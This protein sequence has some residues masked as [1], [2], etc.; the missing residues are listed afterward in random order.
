[1][2]RLRR[3]MRVWDWLP[4]FRAVAEEEHLTRAAGRLHLTPPA[5]SRTLKLL[6]EDLERPL[7]HREGRN[8]VLNPAGRR[9]LVAVRAAMRLVHDAVDDVEQ[10]PVVP[11]TIASTG[12]FTTVGLADTL[13]RVVGA[14]PRV[15]P[16]VRTVAPPEIDKALLQGDLDLM[17]TQTPLFRPGLTTVALCET[18][19]SV[20]CG[21]SH[22]LYGRT[23]VDRDALA[24]H[25]FA[26]PRDDTHGLPIDGWPP[27]WPREVAVVLDRQTLGL[28]LCASGQ[29]LAVLPDVVSRRASSLWRLPVAVPGATR[30]TAIHRASAPGGSGV[31]EAVVAIAGEV[32]AGS[33][34]APDAPGAEI[35]QEP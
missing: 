9:L 25:P 12:L 29:L 21:P 23:D 24:H 35:V 32:L 26:V 19:S 28:D 10:A 15:R 27:D 20:F 8:L 7:F 33:A 5:V 6:E 16:I 13:G 17:F 2:E 34:R 4:A 1:M 18:A 31:V 14:L 30:I 3:V 11:I 22:P